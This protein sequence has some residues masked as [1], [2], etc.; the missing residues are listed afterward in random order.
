MVQ[1]QEQ[2]GPGVVRIGGPGRHEE[3][4]GRGAVGRAAVEGREEFLLGRQRHR[5]ADGGRVATAASG[6]LGDD[7]EE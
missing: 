3:A 6:G 2:V 1:P 4:Q 5:S 7:Q